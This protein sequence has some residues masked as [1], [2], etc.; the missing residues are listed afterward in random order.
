MGQ[1]EVLVGERASVD[2]LT[3]CH[4]LR[5]EGG[6]IM[7]DIHVNADASV[8]EPQPKTRQERMGFFFCKMQTIRI[9]LVD[10]T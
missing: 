8:R 5:G 4:R 1:L 3:A 7:S 2:R 9:N 6:G 10:G